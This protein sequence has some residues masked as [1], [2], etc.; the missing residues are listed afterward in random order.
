MPS[1]SARFAGSFRFRVT[2]LVTGGIS[3]V[4][5]LF[6][7]VLERSLNRLVIGEAIEVVAEEMVEYARYASEHWDDLDTLSRFASTELQE[8]GP[9]TCGY[10]L[11]DMR[12]EERLVVGHF[13]PRQEEE[14]TLDAT[15]V[16]ALGERVR[17]GRLRAPGA[18]HALLRADWPVFIGDQQ[19]GRTEVTKNLRPEERRL[20]AYQRRMARVLGATFLAAAVVGWWLT[21]WIVAPIRELARFANQVRETPGRLS[22]RLPIGP[23]GDELDRLKTDINRMMDALEK[24]FDRERSLAAAVAHEIRSPLTAV[25]TEVDLALGRPDLPQA[26]RALLEGHQQS[27]QSLSDLVEKTLFVIRAEGGLEPP[28]SETFPVEPLLREVREFFLP[29]AE[30]RGVDVPIPVASGTLHA[31]R[32]MARR[33]FANLLDNALRHAPRGTPVAWGVHTS[34]EGTVVSITDHGPGIPPEIRSHLFEPFLR[35]DPSRSRVTGGIGMGLTICAAILRAHGGR[36]W[37]EDTPGG[38]ATCRVLFPAPGNGNFIPAS[39]AR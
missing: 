15:T 16:D 4:I 23:S 20:L 5:L 2:C 39:P 19:V 3:V 11:A 29:V 35:S 31:D 33:V 32:E 24:T 1:A 34:E 10:R 38:G 8:L 22:E 7:L 27:L 36:I 30:D 14:R 13:L 6:S 37:M 18:R 25:R 28:R 12:G 9:D 21:G 17:V 26:I